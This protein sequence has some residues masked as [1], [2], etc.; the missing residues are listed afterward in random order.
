MLLKSNRIYLRSVTVKDAPAIF[1]SIVLSRK[2]LERFMI[3]APLTNTVNAVRAYIRRVQRNMSS[4]R[5]YTFGVF[6]VVE[7]KH[8]GQAGLVRTFQENETAEIGYWIRSDHSGQGY[9][10]GA[11]ALL[12]KL[13]FNEL[14]MH[15][16]ILRAAVDNEASNRVAQKL[17]FQLDGV[18][19]HDGKLERGWLDMNYYSLLENE[20]RLKQKMIDKF[21]N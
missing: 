9:A 13:A 19:R 7:H 18:L 5:E 16:V 17:G 21:I 20:F 14:K 8:L 15:R 1:D 6:S 2:D 3:W 11:S 4:G 12:L 10:T